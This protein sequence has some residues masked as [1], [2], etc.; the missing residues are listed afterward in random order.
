MTALG[1]QP[2]MRVMERLGMTRTVEFDHPGLP[3][4]NP[5][6]RHILFRLSRRRV[7]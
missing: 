4:G 5:L 3:E 7:G 6:R 2:S 1:N